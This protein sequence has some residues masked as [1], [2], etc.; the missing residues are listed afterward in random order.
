MDRADIEREILDEE[1]ALAEV[2]TLLASR[3]PLEAWPPELRDAFGLALDE[4]AASPTE[5]W[6]IVTLRRHLFGAAAPALV[7]AP[8]GPSGRDRRRA[9]RLRDG[10]VS[11]RFRAGRY[12]V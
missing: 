4:A 1:H 2:C 3:R 7:A 9:E 5:R 10:L 12:L 8:A 11:C 6:K